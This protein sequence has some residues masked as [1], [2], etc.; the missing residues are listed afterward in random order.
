MFLDY[1]V[2]YLESVYVLKFLCLLK[3][4]DVLYSN[5]KVVFLLDKYVNI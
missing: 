1:L 5:K 4:R 3:E 2:G